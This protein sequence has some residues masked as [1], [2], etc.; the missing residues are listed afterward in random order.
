MEHFFF[1]MANSVD[2]DKAA[3][4]EAACSRSV[5]FVQSCLSHCLQKSQIFYSI[6]KLSS[7][8]VVL[9]PVVQSIVS[10]TSSLRG[11][12]VKSFTTL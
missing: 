11:Q 1:Q 12:L 7:N 9:G 5:L 4:L 10:L 2:S 6:A 8:S 3:S